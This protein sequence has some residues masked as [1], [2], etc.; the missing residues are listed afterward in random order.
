M[1]TTERAYKFH[2]V[3]MSK[4][5]EKSTKALSSMS[6]AFE[7]NFCERKFHKLRLF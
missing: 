3:L 1:P 4:L 7:L 6:N 5:A 2:P